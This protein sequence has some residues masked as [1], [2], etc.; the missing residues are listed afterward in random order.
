MYY[1]SIFNFYNDLHIKIRPNLAARLQT[2]SY[3]YSSFNDELN[4]LRENLI[5]IIRKYSTDLFVQPED[6]E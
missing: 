1:K 5:V 6:T 4:L 3:F 2:I